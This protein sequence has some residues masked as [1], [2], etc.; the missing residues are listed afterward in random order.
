FVWEQLKQP[1]GPVFVPNVLF[2]TPKFLLVQRHSFYEV[3]VTR[4]CCSIPS[5][6][7]AVSNAFTCCAALSRSALNCAIMSMC[8]PRAGI[9]PDTANYAASEQHSQSIV[10]LLRSS[11]VL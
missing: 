4:E 3:H 2:E 6:P 5:M 10:K 9:V 1:S 8:S 11:A 7:F